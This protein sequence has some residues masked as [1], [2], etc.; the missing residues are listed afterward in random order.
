MS[1]LHGQLALF[2]VQPT[3]AVTTWRG[4]TVYEVRTDRPQYLGWPD[5][6]EV[7]DECGTACTSS[8]ECTEASGLYDEQGRE[9]T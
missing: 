5:T 1:E 3:L 9:Q 6:D 7:C 8:K 4:H 2:Q